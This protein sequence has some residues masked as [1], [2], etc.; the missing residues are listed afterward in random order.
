MLKANTDKNQKMLV[1]HAR[2]LGASVAVTSGVHKGFVD[3]VIGYQ[4]KNYM[5]EIK[6]DKQPPSKQR[7]TDHQVKF[8]DEWNG[9]ICVVKNVDEL[10]E[11]LNG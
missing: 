9:Q 8:H 3:V 1:A 11:L 7:L 6:N 4:G 10:E 5:V 2:T